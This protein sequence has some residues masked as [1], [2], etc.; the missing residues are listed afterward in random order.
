MKDAKGHG[1]NAQGGGVPAHQTGVQQATTGMQRRQ[2]EAIAG[3]INSYPGGDKSALADHFASGLAGSNPKFDAGKFKTAA[4]TGNMGRTD[5]ADPGMQRRHYEAVAGLL[6]NYGASH[7][8][9]GAADH[10]TNT[11][12]RGNPNFNAARFRKAAG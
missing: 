6:K 8:G 10:F 3:A 12:G 1:S 4:T 7:P 5:R 9:S 11:L 2:Y